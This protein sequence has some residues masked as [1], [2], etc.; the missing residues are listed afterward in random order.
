MDIFYTHTDIINNVQRTTH[1]VGRQVQP[2][3]PMGESIGQ[4]I[5]GEDTT[6]H[7]VFY[8]YGDLTSNVFNL[9][10]KKYLEPGHY[11]LCIDDHDLIKWLDEKFQHF[12]T[13]PSF[14]YSQIK[15]K[16]KTGRFYCEGL[17]NELVYEV[18]GYIT[19]K[20]ITK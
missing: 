7:I 18:E 16:F 8:N 17:P 6:T 9:K 1:Y 13:Y 14:S 5:N 4:N 2:G 3:N 19:N 12:I 10:Y 15:S 20:L 11:G